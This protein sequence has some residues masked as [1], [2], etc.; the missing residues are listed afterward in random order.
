MYMFAAGNARISRAEGGSDMEITGRYATAICYAEIIE[1]EAREQIQ[2]MCDYLCTT[3]SLQ[4]L[5]V[6]YNVSNK[7][8]RK[9]LDR[10]QNRAIIDTIR[11]DTTR[12][13]TTRLLCP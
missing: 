13:D 4:S 11:H 6:C 8:T 10:M 5:A 9:E 3:S 1:D 2:R 12:H 7:F